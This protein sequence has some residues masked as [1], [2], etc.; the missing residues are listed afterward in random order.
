MWFASPLS[1]FLL[2]SIFCPLSGIPHPAAS[3]AVRHPLSGVPSAELTRVP[4][5]SPP[6]VPVF[7]LILTLDLH[8]CPWRSLV[9]RSACS[10]VQGVRSSS[11][12]PAPLSPVQRS[13]FQRLAVPVRHSSLS[14]SA[15]RSARPSPPSPAS[16][17]RRARLSPP[18]PASACRRAC[19]PPLSPASA[20][21]RAHPPPLSLT[22]A[23]RSAT[24]SPLSPA[25]AC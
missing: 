11:V 1:P 3:V 10:S 15:C 24:P 4:W 12:R 17:C 5:A 18:S 16:A 25:S 14:G 9:Q 8:L 7:I 21:R 2:S 13:A 20:C 19:P 22:S 23:C 6:P